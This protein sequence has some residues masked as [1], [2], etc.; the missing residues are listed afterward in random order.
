[1]RYP[2][3]SGPGVAVHEDMQALPLGK[4]EVRSHG[5]NVAL[6][7]FGTMLAPALEAGAAYGATVVNM[8]FV[9]PL[10]EQLVIELARTHG[11]L[12]TV[13][14]NTVAGGAGAAVNECLAAAGLIT[15]VV[16]LGLPDEFPEHGDSREILAQYGLDA[17]GIRRTILRYL[18]QGSTAR[19]DA[20]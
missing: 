3:G 5:K 17:A 19:A 1:V 14:E 6:L 16:N 11:L 2:R 15:P 9:K 18:P 4:A 7:A 12:V 10:D 13:E 20:R 8:R